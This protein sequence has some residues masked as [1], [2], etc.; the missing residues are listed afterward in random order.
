MSRL[1]DA[2]VLTRVL[3]DITDERQHQENIGEAKRAAG[4]DWRSCAD[5]RM[6]GGDPMRY[7]VL[8]EEF[9][10]VANAMLEGAGDAHLRAELVQVAAVAVAWVE[11]IDRRRWCE[12]RRACGCRVVP[13]P[14][15][16]ECR[17]CARGR[18]RVAPDVKAVPE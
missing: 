3:G 1:L 16:S 4:K 15:G 2:M 13:Y 7:L 9:G 11:A 5:P 18:H 6:P 8:G 14:A 12:C 10:E 17:D